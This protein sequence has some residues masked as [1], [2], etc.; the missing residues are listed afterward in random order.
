[1]LK[2]LSI[3]DV[4]SRGGGGGGPVCETPDFSKFMV[5]PNGQGERGQVFAI[6][7]GRLLWTVPNY[8][9]QECKIFKH[10][11]CKFAHQD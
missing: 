10:G 8:E 4:C 9:M 6:L 11:I 3:Q 2:G 7:C 5:C 1:M